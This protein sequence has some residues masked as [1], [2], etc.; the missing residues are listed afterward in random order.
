MHASVTIMPRACDYN[1][2]CAS[3]SLLVSLWRRLAVA[4]QVALAPPKPPDVTV[5]RPARVFDGDAMHE[6]WAV[7]VRGDRIDAV[8]PA[9]ERGGRRARRSSICRARR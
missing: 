4:G 9:D 5:L 6:G 8:G 2:R 7:R 1:A 3:P